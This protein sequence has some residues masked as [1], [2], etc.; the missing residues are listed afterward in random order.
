MRTNTADFYHQCKYRGSNQS[1]DT[2]TL[3][4]T[5]MY[6]RPALRYTHTCTE[7]NVGPYL[8]LI[9]VTIFQTIENVGPT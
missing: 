1:I 4:H 7:G 5:Y 2:P 6:Q 8:G 3:S 9:M